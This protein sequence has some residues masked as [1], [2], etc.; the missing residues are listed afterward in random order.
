M[1]GS[2]N[3]YIA[4]TG[5]NQVLVETLLAGSYT[6]SMVPT[7]TLASPSGVAVDGNGTIYISDSGNGRVLKETLS[8]GSYTESPVPTSVVNPE[9][10]AADGSGNVYI[11][12]TY[13][14]RVLKETLSAGSHHREYSAE[15][16]LEC[17]LWGC[18]RWGWQRLHLRYIQQPDIERGPRGSTE[19]ELCVD[20]PRRNEQ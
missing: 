8:T 20:G 5:N 16:Q 18:G 9:G 19:P 14:N 11:S 4:D 7:S 17:S 3:V 6:G 10:V 1:D 12:D 15:Q 13:N 2:G